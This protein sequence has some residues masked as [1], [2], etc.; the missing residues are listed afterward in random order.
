MINQKPYELPD[1]GCTVATVC[2]KNGSLGVRLD[3]R[4]GSCKSDEVEASLE[5][6]DDE[7]PASPDPEGDGEHK[8]KKR[9]KTHRL[10]KTMPELLKI[11]KKFELLASES[12]LAQA[13]ADHAKLLTTPRRTDKIFDGLDEEGGN[14]LRCAEIGRI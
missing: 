10:K 4:K 7:G 2:E 14:W 11:R 9:R 5:G 6:F 13:T 12:E 1:H 8:E 3:C